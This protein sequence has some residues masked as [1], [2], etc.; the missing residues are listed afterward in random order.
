[1]QPFLLFF[2]YI[3]GAYGLAALFC[4]PFG[5][6]VADA[7]GVPVHKFISR[8]G[9]LIALLGFW[10]LLRALRL[11]N[12]QALGYALPRADFLRCLG[13]GLIAGILILA[14]LTLALLLLDIR[15]ASPQEL[16]RLW[17][18]LLQGLLGGLAVAFIEETF[19]RGA[20]FSA[21][22]RRRQLAAAIVLPSVLYAALHF[23]K[24]QAFADGAEVNLE[25]SLRSVGA[26]FA[27]LWQWQNLDSF[28]ALFMVGV[29]LALVR[30]RSGHIAWGIGLHAGWVLVIKLTHTYSDTNGTAELAFLA[31]SYDGMI[32]WL[33]AAWIGL[34]AL[35]FFWLFGKPPR[36]ED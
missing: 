24:P 3:L 27:N 10:P 21:I 15:T 8:G 5:Q 22:M 4:V 31:G 9:L 29:F 20:M 23:L 33:A 30:W 26:G 2:F 11:A 34:L 18:A 19:F 17:R 7:A 13:Q 35:G 36:A 25:A 12:R 6:A 14:G 32:G 16:G 1:M 28:I